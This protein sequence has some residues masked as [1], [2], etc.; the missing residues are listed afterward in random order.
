MCQTFRLD[1]SLGHRLLQIDRDLA[2]KARAKGCECG[3]PLHA[4]PYRRKPRGDLDLGA[5]EDE[6]AVRFSFCCGVEGCRK[7]TT[8]PSARFLDRRVYLGVIVVLV[9]ALRQGPTRMR[10]R[11][12]HERLGVSRRTVERWHAWWHD[13]FPSTHCW[14]A[15]RA[16]LTCGSDERPPRSLVERFD[17]WTAPDQQALL[18]TALLPPSS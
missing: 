12:L 8:P 2:E 10:V 11:V 9:G 13:E 6:F 1:A 16:L 18:M 14:R 17:A 4:A 7:R 15:L 5:N 3:G